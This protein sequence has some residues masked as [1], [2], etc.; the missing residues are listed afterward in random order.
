MRE[1]IISKNY[2][3]DL[4]E[5][6]RDSKIISL[7]INLRLIEQL[8]VVGID[9]GKNSS[10]L[11]SATKESLNHFRLACFSF[12]E[13]RLNPEDLSKILVGTRHSI[14]TISEQTFSQKEHWPILRRDLLRAF[15]K[16]GLEADVSNLIQIEK[17]MGGAQ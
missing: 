15:G 12:I 6:S 2:K 3:K 7:D 9:G 10:P 8:L 5:D 1:D 17:T 11:I 14:L 13:G 16:N 4:S